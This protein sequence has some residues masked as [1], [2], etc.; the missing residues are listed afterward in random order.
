MVKSTWQWRL[1]EIAEPSGVDYSALAIPG[2][3]YAAE[4]N[5]KFAKYFS[6]RNTTEELI[7]NA[8]SNDDEDEDVGPRTE[9]QYHQWQ[10]A[11]RAAAKTVLPPR[12]SGV[13][14]ARDV[15]ARTRRLLQTREKMK[16]NRNTDTEY[17]KFQKDIKE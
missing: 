16:S 7:G 9:S 8:V 10:K 3:S 6:D 15:S 4:F 12:T 5:D 2:S 17:D 13:L 14:T 1:R 11:I